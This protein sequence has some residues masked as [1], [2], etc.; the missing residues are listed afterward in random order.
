[1]SRGKCLQVWLNPSAQKLWLSLVLALVSSM[2]ALFWGKLF[3]WRS[4]KDSSMC[5]HSFVTPIERQHPFTIDEPKSQKKLSLA[6]LNSLTYIEN[7]RHW[8]QWRLWEGAILR[9]KKYV[10]TR[11]KVSRRQ[12]HQVHLLQLPLPTFIPL[13]KY[14]P[15]W[16]VVLFPRVTDFLPLIVTSPGSLPWPSSSHTSSSFEITVYQWSTHFI[17]C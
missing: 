8:K 10:A 7:Q 6:R 4:K 17:L 14:F 9:R 16:N 13:I 5:P 1:M 2:W 12:N 3:P 11:V 15:F